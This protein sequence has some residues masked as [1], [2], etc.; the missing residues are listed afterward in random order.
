MDIQNEGGFAIG[1]PIWKDKTFFFSTLDIYRFRNAPSS[2]TASVPTQL[3]RQGDFSEVLASEGRQ[4]YDPLSTTAL[5]GGGF[6]RTPFAN[7]RLPSDRIS[8]VSSSLQQGYLPPN[9]PGLQNNWVGTARPITVDK[10]QFTVKVDHHLNENHRFTFAYEAVIPLF[11]PEFSGESGH[12]F[13][14][15]GQGYL[16][17][18]LSRGFM[19]DRDSE[20]WRFAHLWT[21]SPNLLVNVRFAATRNPQRTL[22][23]WPFDGPDSTA[24]G[25]ADAGL[26]GTLSE[27]T[28]KVNIEG[29]SRYG[30]TFKKLLVASNKIP[31]TVTTSWYKG[32]HNFKFGGEYITLP[33]KPAFPI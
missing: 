12:A 17:P 16:E 10:D 27:A 21:A 22:V 26:T 18:Q 32:S 3:M 29:V 9:Q 15:R 13:I 1:G 33:F 20:R 4:I 25:G 30:P 31:F 24:T 6:T 23:R 11:A 7:N 14:R 8:S 19:D 2:Q 28:P 5:P